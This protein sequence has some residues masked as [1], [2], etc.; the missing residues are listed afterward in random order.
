MPSLRL[1]RTHRRRTAL[2]ERP[3]DEDDIISSTSS[4]FDGDGETLAIKGQFLLLI[5]CSL[6]LQRRASLIVD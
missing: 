2:A 3:L 4:I 1:R 5:H 6:L